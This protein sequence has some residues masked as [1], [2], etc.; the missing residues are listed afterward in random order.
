MDEFIESGSDMN[1]SALS[2]C[3]VDSI[4]SRYWQL[5]IPKYI[6]WNKIETYFKKKIH[7][8]YQIRKSKMD[9]NIV[10]I[11]SEKR[12]KARNKKRFKIDDVV[13]KFK[14]TNRKNWLKYQQNSKQKK[15]D[16]IE[17]VETEK[18]V[19]E[20]IKDVLN[21]RKIDYQDFLSCPKLINYT[22]KLKIALEYNDQKG[23]EY[24]LP[25][26]I[27]FADLTIKTNEKKR[28]FYICGAPN[29]GKTTY[30][31]SIIHDYSIGPKN[32]D[33]RYFDDSKLW[34]V[35]DEWTK[36]TSKS[37]GIDTLNQIMDGECLLNTKGSTKRVK[38]QHI[39]LFCSNFEIETTIPNEFID[40]FQTRVNFRIFEKKV[41]EVTP[42]SVALGKSDN[43]SLVLS[44]LD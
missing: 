13:L 23:I 34:I 14:R 5:E 43:S 38:N 19:K 4:D 29:T 2:D 12:L 9:L 3:L 7:C 24:E 36:E 21:K 8:K 35:F 39:L 42:N 44:G 30:W 27:T 10:L 41:T 28:H 18:T 31:K 22:S 32:N 1:N 20:A 33:W 11:R 37:M 25:K 26:T 15:E 17:T 16:Q 40:S 6:S